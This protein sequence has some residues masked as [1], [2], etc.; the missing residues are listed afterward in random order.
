MKRVT[1]LFTFCFVL[2]LVV[3]AAGCAQPAHNG[4]GQGGNANAAS[5][6]AT[7]PPPVQPPPKATRTTGTIKVGSQPAGATVL[8]MLT[9]EGGASPPEPR[10]TTPTTLADLSP[11]KYTVHLEMR[12]YKAFQKEVEVKAGE[13]TTVVGVL[14]R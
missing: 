14:K 8:L 3:I 5:G 4:N 2:A 6:A 13:V 12:G 10:G 9:D 1:S 11:G 7:Q